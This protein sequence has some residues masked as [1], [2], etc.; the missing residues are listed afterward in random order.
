MTSMK[1]GLAEGIILWQVYPLT[2]S[3]NSPLAVLEEFESGNNDFGY[4]NASFQQLVDE[5]K[6]LGNHNDSVE[7]YISA[8]KMLLNDFVFIPVFYKKEYRYWALEI[9]I[10]YLIHLQSSC[11]SGMLNIMNNRQGRFNVPF[12]WK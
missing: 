5:I 6:R 11:F 8:E 7:K 3:Y 1:D 4:S 10:L 12:F 2:G 9:M